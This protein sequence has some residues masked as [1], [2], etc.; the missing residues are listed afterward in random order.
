MDSITEPI[1][2]PNIAKNP[3]LLSNIPDMTGYGD[4]TMREKSDLRRRLHDAGKIRLEAET[5]RCGKNQT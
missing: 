3:A 4:H 2:L 5:T 1:I